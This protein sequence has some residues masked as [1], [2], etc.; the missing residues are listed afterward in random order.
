VKRLNK[1]LVAVVPALITFATSMVQS[2]AC[3]LGMGEPKI[4]KSLRK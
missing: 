3:W 4:P 2:N 1:L